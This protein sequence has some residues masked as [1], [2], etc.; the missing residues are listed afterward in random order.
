MTYRVETYEKTFAGTDS[1]IA[2]HRSA[3]TGILPAS[4]QLEM[5]VLGLLRRGEFTPLELTD[6]AFLRPFTVP[7]DGRGTVTLDVTFGPHPRFEVTAG[8][9]RKALSTGSG[10]PL[11]AVPA[12]PA[13]WHVTCE[14]R[15]TPEALYGSWSR[16]GLEYGPDFR[17]VRDLRVGDGVAEAVLRCDAEPLPWY[18]HPLLVDGVFQ[19]VSCALQGPAE[20]SAPVPLLPI[21]VSRFSLL[22]G[23][24][25]LA[26]PVTVRVRRTAVEGAYS[27]ADALVLTPSGEPVAEL[28]GVR[29]RR[30]PPAV[31]AAASVSPVL[32]V[33]A[34]SAESAAL[35]RLATRIQWAEA[36]AP[37]PREPVTGTWVVLH[38]GDTDALGVHTARALR[39]EG[40]EVVEVVPEG[41]G[42][43][44]D[45]GDA[46][47][48]RRIMP[49]ID[50][51]AFRRLWEDIGEPVEG[52]V[53]LWNTGP[54]R[55]AR[56]E[57]RTGLYGALA[58]VK[59]LGERQRKARFFVVTEHAQPVADEDRPVPERAAVWGLIRTAAVEYPGLRPR[60]VDLGPV[61]GAEAA[62]GSVAAALARTAS[63][64]TAS[65][66]G[67]PADGVPAGTA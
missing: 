35:A 45:A 56:E 16:H 8:P 24:A 41:R 27:V 25:R 6:L 18:V 9:D 36:P 37:A 3:G 42:G 62:A 39:A 2:Q 23:F 19:V 50:E 49:D 21:G 60:L 65:A 44:G 46:G 32:S 10:R 66:D 59:T 67:V 14:E 61:G 26:G 29:M 30:M 64:G 38:H 7:D 51:D 1:F 43:V 5:A 28:T 54:V 34:V 31:P 17:T 52:V 33:S 40:A 22:P 53:H 55:P 58:A 11:P 4:M 15:L 47:D 13:V 57:L 20:R 48:G 63:A 12:P